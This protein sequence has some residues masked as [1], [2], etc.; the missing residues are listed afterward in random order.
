MEA[1]VNQ[2]SHI[3]RKIHFCSCVLCVP[4]PAVL[5]L[6]HF[7]TIINHFLQYKSWKRRNQKL[8]PSTQ[9]PALNLKVCVRQI[10][11]RSYLHLI[12]QLTNVLPLSLACSVFM[13]LFSCCVKQT[14]PIL[15][16]F[17]VIHFCRHWFNINQPIGTSLIQM[18]ADPL[19]ACDS[20]QHLLSHVKYY[21]F[22]YIHFLISGEIL[23]SCFL[24]RFRFNCL[25]MQY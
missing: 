18:G 16:T 6:S 23:V 12:N 2:I 21:L 4:R 22:Y 11:I 20:G 8:L 9:Q 19:R 13:L 25:T 15:A 5:M 17:P 7:L 24:H 3:L 1:A 14:L 10:W